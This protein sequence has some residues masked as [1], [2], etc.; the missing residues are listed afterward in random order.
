M[1]PPMVAATTPIRRLRRLLGKGQ[2]MSRLFLP[3]VLPVSFPSGVVFAWHG[4]QDLAGGEWEE[5]D[6]FKIEAWFAV[7]L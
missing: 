5:S 6:G 3:L 4:K 7:L 1:S 2:T